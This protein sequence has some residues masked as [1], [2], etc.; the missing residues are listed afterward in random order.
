MLEHADR[1]DAVERAFDIPVVDQFEAHTVRDPGLGGAA[2]RDLELLFRQ[3]DAEHVHIGDAFE[4]QRHA[5]P[6]AADVEHGLPRLQ[7]QFRSDV[8]LLVGLSLFERLVPGAVVGA[9]VLPVGIQE[10]VVE[11]IRK[12]VVVRD[13]ALRG[14][15]VVQLIE[16]GA[17]ALRAAGF[18]ADR[19]VVRPARVPCDEVE[20]LRYST[21]RELH[22]PVHIGFRSPDRGIER[23]AERRARIGEMQG[24][25]HPCRVRPA[26][27]AHAPIRGRDR[28]FAVAD[29]P[30]QHA[31]EQQH[32]LTLIKNLARANPR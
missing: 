15:A 7:G 28:Q 17:D 24:D 5:A 22:P 13:V 20:Q 23:D 18:A 27:T 31:I 11:A 14:A 2:A 32:D 6:A 12:V 16:V 25:G 9:A 29:E 10:E 19:I 21:C 26:V 30:L 4:V 3:C 8:R 1:N